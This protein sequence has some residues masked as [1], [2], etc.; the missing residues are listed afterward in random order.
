MSNEGRF[1]TGGLIGGPLDALLPLWW[2]CPAEVQAD[3]VSRCYGK[4]GIE[5][6]PEVANWLGVIFQDNRPR[7]VGVPQLFPHPVVVAFTAQL[8]VIDGDMR[9][10]HVIGEILC[11]AHPVDVG[12][13]TDV[14]ERFC[15]SRQ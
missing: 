14:I 8:A 15:A 1:S 5:L 3:N 10:A 13:N 2:T 6:I 12:D 11:I 9:R 7:T 4:C